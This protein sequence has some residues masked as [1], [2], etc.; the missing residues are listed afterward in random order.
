[1]Y[2]ENTDIT[3]LTATSATLNGELMETK[4]ATEVRLYWGSTDGGTDPNAWEHAI[5]MGTQSVGQVSTNITGL[6][7]GSQYYYRYF[8]DSLSWDEWA[9]E[10]ATFETLST[11]TVDNQAPTFLANGTAR[12][13]GGFA[14]QNR[15]DITICWGMSDGGTNT[16]D[17][18][19]VVPLGT[20]PN[21]RFFTDVSGLLFPNTYYY[22]CYATNAYGD[23]WADSSTN[24]TTLGPQPDYPSGSLNYGL[25]NGAANTQLGA[26]DDGLANGQ[27]GGLFS[28][29]PS[30]SQKWTGEVWQGGNT[31]DYYCQMWS[32][33][34]LPP[35]TG[36][37]TFYVHGDDYEA[38]WIDTDISGEFERA[39]DLVSD[40]TP[41]SGE[42]W[43]TPHTETVYLESGVGHA[44]AIAHN[45]GGG[46]DW[47]NL[48]ITPPGSSSQ[49]VNPGSPDQADWWW[50]RHV[51][52]FSTL[53][54]TNRLPEDVTGDSATLR[55]TLSSTA[56]IYDAWVFWG[57]TDRSTNS[58]T[59]TN[60]AFLGTYTNASDVAL[61]HPISG[62]AAGSTNYYT[63]RA[64]NVLHTGWA[65]PSAM[66]ETVD[67]APVVS[68]LAALTDIGSATLRG[69]L[70]D[71]N[72]ADVAIYWGRSD[73]ET[74]KAAWDSVVRLDD[75]LEGPF[76]SAVNAGYGAT[77]YF[78]CYATNTA[79][80]AWADS[81]TNFT[82]LSPVVE[83]GVPVTSGLVVRWDAG[84]IG[85]ADGAQVDAWENSQNPG[86]YDLTRSGGSPKYDAVVPGLND[87]PA[88][89]FSTGGNDWF[90]FS[91]INTIRTAFWVLRDARAAANEQFMMGDLGTYHFHNVG[92][93]IWHG[94]HAHANIRNGSTELNGTVV[95]G[96]NTDRPTDFGII[97]VVTT[98]N[99][100]GNQLS[101]DRSNDGR[102]W[103]GEMA[104]V[105]IYDQPLSAEDEDLVGSFLTWKY[106]L[107]TAY[108]ESYTP[109][110]PFAI[111]NTIV[112]DVSSNAAT[113]NAA[114][115]ATGWV[116][117]VYAYWGAT[118]G[119]TVATNWDSNAYVGAIT[120]AAGALS[121]RVSG[122]PGDTAH[123]YTFK[124]TND[125]TNV[126]AVPSAHFRTLGTPTV[127]NTPATDITQTSATLNGDLVRGGTGEATI[128]WG[129]ADGG[130]TPSAWGNTSV[131]GTVVG[132]FDT[133]VPVVAGGVYYYR[134]YVTNSLNEDWAD[135]TEEFRADYAEV[136]LDIAVNM[137]DLGLSPTNVSGC[138]F[139]IAGDDIDG[140]GD[141]GN[142]PTN[143][144]SVNV[145]ADKSGLGHDVSR[146]GLVDPS[147]NT[148][149]PNGRSVVT[150]DADQ[151]YMATT[152][153]FDP[154]TEYT[155]F[156]VARYS[157]GDNERVISS[158]TRNWR[159]GFHGN[160]TERWYAEGWI[161]AGPTGNADA[162]WHIHAGHIDSDPDPKASFWAD[163]LLRVADGTG[164]GAGNHMIGRL[165]L[166]GYRSNNE[167][168]NCE[169]AEILVFDRVLTGN[170]LRY[171]GLYLENKYKLGT[172]YAAGG[173]DVTEARGTFEVT[174]MLSAPAIS[175]VTVNFAFGG[176]A[177]G[178]RLIHKG[179]HVQPQADMDLNNNGGLMAL[180][181]YGTATLTVGPAGR[182][183]DFNNDADFINSGA[184]NQNDNYMNLFLGY[185]TPQETGTFEF[186]RGADDDR[187]GI[188]LDLDR[189]GVFE[190]TT[191]GLG[192]NRGE[193]LQ[194]DSDGGA[195]SVTLT[196][197][198][199]YMFAV[200]HGEYGGGSQ[201]DVRFKTP[202]MAAETVIKPADPD[203]Y[204]M[205]SDSTN[206][207]TYPA[208]F[209]C[210]TSVE[211][212][213][214]S[215]SAAVTVTP[216]DDLEQE[217]DEGGRISIDSVV[218]AAAGSPDSVM[219]S[220]SSTD[221]EVVNGAATDVTDGTAVLNGTLSM[222]DYATVSVYWGTTDGGTDRSQWEATNVLGFAAEDEPF[223][224]ALTGLTGG[225]TY[226]YRCY[227]TNDS[228]LG[229]DWAD[230]TTNFTTDLPL[231]S[232]DDISVAEGDSGNV[233]AVFT[234]G[235]S[236]PTVTDVTAD[237]G[238]IDGTARTAD[239]DYTAVSGSLRIPAGSLS[240]QI[241]VLVH[242]DT[243]PENPPE[244][245]G[246]Q[247]SAV[248]GGATVGSNPGTCVIMDDDAS[249]YLASWKYR[250]PI[251]FSGYSGGETLTNWPALIR[252]SEN[253]PDFLYDS[254]GSPTGG[255]LRFADAGVKA[256]L[257]FEIELWDATGESAVW[258]Q[259][260]ELS[261]SNTMIWAYWG[262]PANTN[263]P[264]YATDGSTWD[265]TFAAVYHLTSACDDSTANANH[266]PINAGAPTIAA[267]NVI[268]QAYDF[269]GS[270][271]F[272]APDAPSLDLED[273]CT[274]SG[275]FNCR[276]LIQWRGMIAKG[277]DS[278]YELENG[279][280]ASNFRIRINNPGDA[281]S[282]QINSWSANTWYYIVG[283]YDMQ[284]TRLYRNGVLGN[285]RPLTQTINQNDEGLTIGARH[286]N[287]FVGVLDEWRLSNV[288]RG[289]DWI[290][291]SYDNQV[292]PS[293]FTEYG[294][295]WHKPGT[296]LIVR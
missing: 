33:Y 110:V 21:A 178:G 19:H 240:T 9:H 259:V 125:A 18:D 292:K 139:W 199:S 145:W 32:G 174:A 24:F 135:S 56:S 66:F 216:V 61:A 119:G 288:A 12:L 287:N 89:L 43:N 1:M 184:I 234:I 73:G 97:S 160:G 268:G 271:R 62:L 157:G 202:S 215:L 99:V 148:N 182:G 269:D 102:S 101:R 173:A 17:W 6:V 248:A 146:V 214:G 14:N 13:R 48:T 159:F 264:S 103:E 232:V 98:G 30:T 187:M 57:P 8:A 143:G 282:A 237:Y 164:S 165:A 71:G 166:G 253:L 75:M 179:Y 181:P 153:N 112:S 60:R 280:G 133:T 64:S 191:A 263:L 46:G 218:N 203:Q 220:I 183:L 258:V 74:N 170:E 80:D 83:P 243:L 277:N 262:N 105:L 185:F 5:L 92:A 107:T 113:L 247:L 40:N 272:R 122:L 223:A 254:F 249:T 127:S 41:E 201:V 84:S 100:Q 222:G 283:T 2:I 267:G 132:P 176:A 156:S 265:E 63:F 278:A 109:P 285:T 250:M 227:A 257:S 150:F 141:T 134:C 169:V 217:E 11:P 151:D 289:A 124:A 136:S 15:A 208:D 94:S 116:F 198:L 251:T 210:N 147:L 275:W 286:N 93:R 52:R 59:W 171:V 229:E 207:T 192:S 144:A 154:H 255:D 261:G 225:Q 233:P 26:I 16:A 22:T 266:A 189:D 29:T 194:W 256:L 188:W 95:D 226:Y 25:Y 23:D 34:F 235:L 180:T 196:E 115:S 149:G 245:F 291:A 163:G 38:L 87:K 213:A 167:E 296:L 175:N 270:S 78:R 211:I 200:T 209:T 186:R 42:S 239:G 279:R 244:S 224:V 70:T 274:M 242:G 219:L 82:T 35:L 86:T 76:S 193:Q 114:L 27:N 81:T 36:T 140:D 10:T 28:L 260:P 50:D 281:A 273:G 51:V 230:A 290:Q 197:G 88:V 58:A 7:G 190:S 39:T 53:D 130:T 3:N 104:E 238:T 120:N 231:L 236:A 85:V 4:G 47:V 228:N 293:T 31:A 118:N 90:S 106:G 276:E 128:Y 177:V 252:L 142:N 221:P 195:K 212:P 65:A 161:Y 121:Y 20:Q 69:E 172:A 44:I 241:T 67:V 37:Y 205:W 79:G 206:A 295:V 138:I 108:P 152:Y 162:N 72:A 137:P 91:R 96:V 117:D 49:R 131:V 204:G 126:W 294:D 45:E 77:F 129:L 111:A 54:V 155:I 55:G 158:A 68:N 168:S 284:N 123:Y 246:M